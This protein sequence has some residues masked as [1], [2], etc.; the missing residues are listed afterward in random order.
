MSVSLLYI[1]AVDIEFSTVSVQLI[2]SSPLKF[3]TSDDI[4]LGFD[5]FV[6]MS[7]K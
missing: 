7:I 2:P 4:L 1:V 6:I 5:V 3:V